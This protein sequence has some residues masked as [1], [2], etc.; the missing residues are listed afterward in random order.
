MIKS[1]STN[2]SAYKTQQ[3]KAANPVT[4]KHTCPDCSEQ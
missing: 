3:H 2:N 4:S 1:L